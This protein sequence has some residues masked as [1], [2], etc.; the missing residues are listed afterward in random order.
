MRCLNRQRAN[1]VFGHLF[2]HGGVLDPADVSERERIFEKDGALRWAD[3]MVIGRCR[4]GVS[5]EQLLIRMGRRHKRTG[6]LDLHATKLSDLTDI[7]AD[8]K[9]MLWFADADYE[10]LI[11][12][13]EGCTPVHQLKAWAHALL[14]AQRVRSRRHE[15]QLELDDTSMG[16]GRLAEL[17]STL[18]DTSE[19]FTKYARLL[20]QEGWD[21]HVAALETRAGSRIQLET[22]KEQQ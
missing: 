4:I 11:V 3:G 15:D 18:E 17:K 8:E 9:Y 12:L 21:L 6:S 1:L 10:A 14:L 2:Q 13:K 5:L 20:E 19:V 7:F 16:Q 22:R